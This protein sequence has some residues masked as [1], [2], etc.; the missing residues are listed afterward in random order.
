M[1]RALLVWTGLLVAIAVPFAFAASS[2]LLAWR[3]AP[4]IVAGLAGVAALALLF[5]QPVLIGGYLPGLSGNRG[6]RIHRWI[7]GA[8]VLSVM[9]HVGGL[10]ITSPPDVIDVLLFRSPTPFSAWGAIA[11]WALFAAAF[12]A[13]LRH[14]LRPRLW[15]IG[16]SVF[17]MVAVVG[18][19]VHALLVE[20]TME[21]VSKAVLC[22]L[23]VLAMIATMI[24]L[25]VWARRPR[26]RS[27]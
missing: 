16:H 7:G 2:P 27:L 20:G 19:V 12:M 5:V 23:A 14:R 4:Y 9:I 3:Y 18:G 15:R 8:L 21:T 1:A 10:W 25:R 11:M 22:A 13:V 6:R 24:D 26:K 17:V